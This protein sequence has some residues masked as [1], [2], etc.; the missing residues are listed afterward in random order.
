MFTEQKY[1]QENLFHTEPEVWTKLSG[2]HSIKRRGIGAKLDAEM[3]F[4]LWMI[5]V[6]TILS[7]VPYFAW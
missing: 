1:L 3:F 7:M 5:L 6:M 2:V 4:T